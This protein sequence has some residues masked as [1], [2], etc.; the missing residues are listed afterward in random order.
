ME[1]KVFI[2]NSRGLNLAGILE[3]P[4]DEGIFPAVILLHGITGYKEKQHIV[5]LSHDLARE[6]IASIRFDASGIGESQGSVEEDYRI[7][8][9]LKDIEDIFK[10]LRGLPFID[11]SH[12]G[13][14]GHSLGGML[15]I[16]YSAHKHEVKAVC[17]ISTPT[18]IEKIT[19]IKDEINNW[20]ETG[21]F[22]KWNFNNR[23][24]RIPFA[25][26]EDASNFD[27]E[28]EIKKVSSPKL[29][30]IGKI[31]GAV[32]PEDTMRVYHAAKEPKE[33]IEVDNMGHAYKDFPD[34][35]KEVDKNVVDFFTP[36][37]L[38]RSS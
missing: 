17:A 35:I 21:W 23:P 4:D 22:D 27:V 28:S 13:I 29:I 36:I 32:L 30:I 7:S 20:K 10:Y 31:D 19:A 34:Q 12:I 26:M 18:K 8:H 33:L 11:A 15:A 25:F 2:E 14:W 9:Y 24:T 16:I 6:G 5:A 38:G 37:L 1:E 3:K